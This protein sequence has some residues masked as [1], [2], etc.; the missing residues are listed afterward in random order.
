MGSGTGRRIAAVL[1]SACIAVS[2][3]TGAASAQTYPIRPIRIVVPY[4]PGN[5]ADV[6][7]RTLAEPLSKRLGQP[8]VIENKP[9]A[10]GIIGVDAV[11]HA[12]PDGHTLLL[13]SISLV[14]GPAILKQVPYD[15]ATD[16][17]PVALIGQTSMMLVANPEFPARDLAATVALLKENPGKYSYAHFGVGSLS[18]ISMESFKRAAGIDIV[19][20]PYRG[21]AQALTDVLAGQLPLMFDAMT[22]AYGHVRAGKTRAIAVSAAQRSSFAP[23]VPTLAESG[24]SALADYNVEAWSALLAPA[25][26]PPAIIAQIH[27]AT[28]SAMEDADF[29]ARAAAQT[30]EIYPPRP[31]DEVGRFLRAELTRWRQIVRDIGLEGSQ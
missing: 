27:A 8:I 15:V 4:P 9:G 26:T 30:L 3:I 31:P 29:R 2:A 13:N 18:Q 23:E 6:T 21:A 22:S 19:G 5:L 17:A 20:V 14:I 24:L 28:M 1:A 11:V 16:L 12:A 7:A 10:T 25:A